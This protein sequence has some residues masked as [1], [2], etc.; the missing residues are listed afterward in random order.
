MIEK[1][2]E[3]IQNVDVSLSGKDI[4]Q[5]DNNSILNKSIL[6]TD[7]SFQEL[8]DKKHY[9]QIKLESLEFHL[10]VNCKSI[11]KIFLMISDKNH[12]TLE[13]NYLDYITCLIGTDNE[14]D[15][16]NLLNSSP[17]N[18]KSILEPTYYEL[19]N[20]TKMLYIDFP[21]LNAKQKINKRIVLKI[22]SFKKITSLLN[23]NIFDM[24]DYIEIFILS[25]EEKEYLDERTMLKNKLMGKFNQNLID[26]NKE[27][28]FWGVKPL[29][30]E[31]PLANKCQNNNLKM[32][33]YYFNNVWNAIEKENLNGD[34]LSF[35]GTPLRKN[36]N[37]SKGNKN[38]INNINND[39]PNSYD[40]NKSSLRNKKKDKNEEIRVENACGNNA[41]DNI[42]NIF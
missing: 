16:Q 8:V 40:I 29:E 6:S 31:I 33:D 34:N 41:C 30:T 17:V 24:S 32:L 21:N 18:V 4:A 19:L 38:S 27:N 37:G 12:E 22:N 26:N 25:C 9:F 3:Q 14:L 36:S 2:K 11:K 7:F 28:Y 10:Y 13:N 15:K 20:R 1:L 42:C 35:S 23:T 5:E 39:L